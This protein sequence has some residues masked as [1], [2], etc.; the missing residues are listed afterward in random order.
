MRN[1][2]EREARLLDRITFKLQCSGNRNQRECIGKPIADLQV[3]V[4]L[5]KALRRKLDGD[6]DFVRMQVGIEVRPIFGQPVEI[7]EGDH[8]IS[9]GACY[10]HP[11]FE[12]GKRDTHIGRMRRDAGVAGPEDCVNPVDP[13]NRRAARAGGA[14]VARRRRII[15]IEATRALQ[16][17]ATC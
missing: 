10:M 16:K 1:A 9:C 2:A 14:L 3:R 15:K 8:A 5:C 12:R 6:D 7:V 4:M 11:G 17:I 13:V